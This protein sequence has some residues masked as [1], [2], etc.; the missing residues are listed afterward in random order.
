MLTAE[1]LV[2]SVFG[3]LTGNGARVRPGRGRG[4]ALKTRASR[5]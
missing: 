4:P 3:A 1:S 2:V 5:R